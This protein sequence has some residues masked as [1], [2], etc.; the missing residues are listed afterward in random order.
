MKGMLR[1]LWAAFTLIELLVVI[2]IIAILAGLLLPALAAAREKAR[3]SSCMNNLKQMAIGFESYFGDYN[4]YLPSWP[5]AGATVWY[6]QIRYPAGSTGYRQCTE[7][8]NCLWD[9]VKNGVYNQAD[10][11]KH[12]QAGGA[13]ES[14]VNYWALQYGGRPGDTPLPIGGTAPVFQRV[15]GFGGPVARTNYYFRGGRLSAAPNGIGY[16]LS[17]GYLQDARVF[18]CPSGTDMPPDDHATPGTSSG[19]N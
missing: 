17:S 1:R 5:G 8:V 18:Y 12:T 15:I 9:L 16:L 10:D 13:G 3:R 7:R 14:Q 4:S 2:A 19:T 6:P 11:G